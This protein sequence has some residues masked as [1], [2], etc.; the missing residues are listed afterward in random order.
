[1]SSTALALHLSRLLDAQLVLPA[2]REAFVFRHALVR[3]AVYATILRRERAEAHFAV[4]AALEQLFAGQLDQHLAD[5]AYHYYEAR[6]WDQ[7]LTY[8]RRAGERAQARFAPQEAGAHFTQAIRAARQQGQAPPADLLRARGQ[9]R[10]LVGDFDGARADLEAALAAARAAADQP[11]EWQ[12]LLDLGHLWASRDYAET[13]EYFRAALRLARGMDDARRLGH[14]LNRVGN[15]HLNRDEVEAALAHHHEALAAFEAAEDMRGLAESLDLL[16]LTYGNQG[17]LR[18]SRDSYQR[19][20]PLLRE[21]NDRRGEAS[22]LSVM[23]DLAGVVATDTAVPAFTLAEARA[24]AEAS[25]QLSRAIGWRAG[26]AYSLTVV[27]GN[28]LAAGDLGRAGQAMALARTVAEEIGHHQWLA[29]A[30]LNT[31]A[32]HA[33]RLDFAAAREAAQQACQLA[34]QVNTRL[35]QRFAAGVLVQAHLELGDVAAAEA[36]LADEPILDTPPQSV[37]ERVVI[38]AWAEIALARGDAAEAVRLLE[39]LAAT[40]PYLAPDRVPPRVWWALGRAWEAAGRLE[41]AAEAYRQNLRANPDLRALGWRL[42]G[43]LSRVLAALGRQAEAA[44]A[45]AE[46]GALIHAIAATLSDEQQRADF[47]RAALR[48]VAGAG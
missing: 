23:A 16:G 29:A 25:L 30:W 44:R 5:L 37:A 43:A 35:W 2:G 32:L 12:T 33:E 21:L 48:R 47:T 28:W 36:A 38:C 13:G 3:E 20:L 17:D 41:E 26:E 42:H 10:E 40:T 8:A 27:G 7:A 6:A 34:R 46:A 11:A 24:C 19:A 22:A 4:A 45:A 1:M 14:S 31:G 15:W 18:R 39:G 9:V